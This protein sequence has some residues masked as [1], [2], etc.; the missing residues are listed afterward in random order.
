VQGRI[1]GR[2]CRRSRSIIEEVKEVFYQNT[3]VLVVVVAVRRKC[4]LQS[5]ALVQQRYPD[6]D[7]DG[8]CD[9]CF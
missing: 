5:A 7:E 9:A 3:L 2:F 1:R 8:E 6:G 4:L